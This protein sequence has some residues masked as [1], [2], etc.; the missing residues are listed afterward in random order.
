[1]NAL[2]QPAMLESL[3]KFQP[4]GLHLHSRFQPVRRPGA[5]PDKAV[6]LL[7]DVDERLFHGVF[8]IN[9]PAKQSKRRPA[10]M[11]GRSHCHWHTDDYA[12]I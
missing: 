8:S 4:R 2:R 11:A 12:K 6:N 5:T 9:R 1:M 10:G 7:L 3:V